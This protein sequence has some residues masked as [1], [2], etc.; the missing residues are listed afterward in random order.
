MVTQQYSL[1]L[2]HHLFN[3][4]WQVP[5][6]SLLTHSS[7]S[8]PVPDQEECSHPLASD[9]GESSVIP[10]HPHRF[11]NSRMRKLLVS[12]KASKHTAVQ[13]HMEWF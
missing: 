1:I 7:L 5:D 8:N 10:A 11:P 13:V 3:L 6:E 4:L 12:H 9:R 2:P